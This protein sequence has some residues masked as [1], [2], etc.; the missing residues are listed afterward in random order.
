MNWNDEKTL[1]LKMSKIINYWLENYSRPLKTKGQLIE[2]EFKLEKFL[3]EHIGEHIIFNIRMSLDD[4][5]KLNLSCTP[6]F[7]FG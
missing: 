3:K 7:D 1:E 6:T 5:E 4:D 2:A